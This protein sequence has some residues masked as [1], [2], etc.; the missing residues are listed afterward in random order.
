MDICVC[1]AQVPFARG[2]AELHMENLIG[3]LRTAGHRA[4]LVRLPVAWER[5]RLFEA[6]F[7]WRLA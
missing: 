4:E 5:G 6:A 7:A 3:A 1:G 2:G